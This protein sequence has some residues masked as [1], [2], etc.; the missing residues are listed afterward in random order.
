MKLRKLS[1]VHKRLLSGILSAAMVLSGL[2]ALGGSTA[3]AA[4]ILQNETISTDYTRTSGNFSYDSGE[5]TAY[6]VG[7]ETLG[8]NGW[9]HSNFGETVGSSFNIAAIEQA[10]DR[11]KNGGTAPSGSNHTGT[12]GYNTDPNSAIKTA[13][14]DNW[15]H[16]RYAF[17]A[18]STV[19][20]TITYESSTS[21]KPIGATPPTMANLQNFPLNVNGHIVRNGEVVELSKHDDARKKVEVRRSLKVSDDEQYIIIEYTVHNKSTDSGNNPIPVEFWIGNQTDTMMHRSDNCP[22]ILTDQT[23]NPNLGSDEGITMF[24]SHGDGGQ[25]EAPQYQLTDFKLLTHSGNRDLGVGITKRPS[26][27]NSH[28]RAWVGQWYETPRPETGASDNVRQGAYV[29][30]KGRKTF[31]NV[32]DSSA[33]FSAYMDMAANETKTA[34]FAIRMRTSVYY[35][36]HDYDGAAGT[37]NGFISRPYRSIQ[38]AINAM[39]GYGVKKGYIALQNDETITSTIDIPDGMDITFTSTEFVR[40]SGLSVNGGSEGNPIYN[41]TIPTPVD[42]DAPSK[43]IIR[44]FD[45]PLFN[46]GHEKSKLTIA[47][48]VVDGN[49]VPAV[50]PLIT[51][52]SGE[53]RTKAKSKFVNAILDDTKP[54]VTSTNPTMASAISI[55][56]TAKFE[57]RSGTITD[58]KA[59]GGSAVYIDSTAAKPMDI[60]GEVIIDGNKNK[61]TTTAGENQA[62]VKLGTGK[63]IFVD[64]RGLDGTAK[65]GISVEQSP[66]K[67][68]MGTEAV[69]FEGS[70]V[71]YTGNNFKAD[72]KGT[73]AVGGSTA[74]SVTPHDDPSTHPQTPGRIY[75][76]AGMYSLNIYYVD[77]NGKSMQ[78]NTVHSEFSTQPPASKP[79]QDVNKSDAAAGMVLNYSFPTIFNGWKYSSYTVEPTTATD[80]GVNISST[81]AV[82][83]TMPAKNVNIT[84]K[85]E[86]IGINYVFDPNNG[87]AVINKFETVNPGAVAS[88]LGGLPQ[89][90]RT[91]YQFDGWFPFNDTNPQNGKY[92]AGEEVPGGTQLAAYLVPHASAEGTH[93]YY[94]KWSPGSGTYPIGITYRNTTASL[95]LTFG[96]DTRNLHVDD[97][98]NEM[99][100]NVPGYRYATSSRTPNKGVLDPATGSFTGNMPPLG[101]SLLYRY[102]VDPNALFN[103]NVIHVDSAGNII[104][105]N[106]PTL[107]RRAE[108]PF[109]VSKITLPGYD[110]FRT[111]IAAGADDIPSQF[112]V[113]LNGVLLTGID[114][115]NG[116]VQGYMPNQDV[117]IKFIYN[118]NSAS[119]ITRRFTDREELTK[120]I[121]SDVTNQT[122]NGSV[123]VPAIASMPQLYGYVYDTN[124]SVN[125][126]PPGTQVSANPATGDLFGTMPLSGGVIADYRLS[127]DMSKWQHINFA[128]T[129]NSLGTGTISPTTSARPVLLSDGTAAGDQYAQTFGTI[130]ALGILPTVTPDPYHM[131]EG[132]YFDPA[133]TIP[134]V[135]NMKLA[136]V[137]PPGVRTIYVRLVEDPSK[138]VDIDFVTADPALGSVNPT[139]TYIPGGSPQHLHFDEVWSNVVTPPTTPIANYELK[140][141]TSPA[142]SIMKPTDTVTAGTYKAN[143]GKIGST[144]GLVPGAF[145]ATGHI[146][147]DGSGEIHVHGTQPGN[148]YVVSDP[149][150]IIVGVLPGPPTGTELEFKSLVPGRTYNVREGGPD[151]TA[152]IG[153]PESSIGGSNVSAPK[154]VTIPSIDTNKAVGADPN[155][156]GK[157]QIVIN[158]ADPDA[159]YALI[160]SNGNVVQYPGSDNGWMTPK[161]NNPPTVTFDNLDIGETY[162]VVARKKGNPTETP[163]GNIHA[164]VQVVA[165]PGDMVEA[166]NYTIE[167]RTNGIGANV[168][169][170]TVRGE[171]INAPSYDKIHEN[172][173]FSIHA[174]PTDSNGNHFLYWI[175]MNGRIPGVTG[176]INSNDY[177]GKLSKSNVVFRAVYDLPRLNPAGDKIAPVEEVTRGGSEGEFALDPNG[178]PQLEQD[179]SNPTDVSL[180]NVNRADVRYKIVFNKRTAKTPEVDVVKA[181]P[182]TLWNRYPNAFTAAFALDIKEE[183]YVD[184][185]LVQNASPSN[186]YLKAVVQLDNQDADMLDYEIWDL[187]LNVDAT[188][189][190]TTPTTAA[191]IAIVEPVA[192]NAGLFSFDA[193]VNHTYVLVYAKTFKLYFIDNTPVKNSVYPDNDTSRNF[194]KKIKVRKKDH[195][196]ASEYAADY[197]VVTSYVDGSG[198][199]HLESPFDG[200]DGV[201]YIF[202]DWYK[203]NI[204]TVDTDNEPVQGL[205]FDPNSEVTKTMPIYAYYK[206]NKKAVAKARVD[207]T[208]LVGV[209]N[210]LTLDPYLK[211]GEVERLK[212]AIGIAQNVLD[213]KRGRFD[214]EWD[215]IAERMANYPELQD[216]ID[217]LRRIV[218]EM[219]RLIDQRRN[220]LSSRIG[221]GG[222]GSGSGGR[223]M[224]TKTSAFTSNPQITFT[225]GVDGA[226]EINP[227]TGRWSFV[228]QG[229]LPL[230]NKWAKIQYSNDKG[231]LAT[232]WYRFDKQS[233]L[234][235]GWYRDES[236]GKWYYMSEEAGKK[237]GV[238]QIGWLYKDGKWYYL[239]PVVGEMYVGWHMIG[240]KWYYFSVGNDG[241]PY[242]SLY[243]SETTPDGYKVN[244]DGEWVR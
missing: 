212:I 31:A 50:A 117:T 150:G 11:V 181:V 102:T 58:N 126:T 219:N 223:G 38:N 9:S 119:A 3:H 228:L 241:R 242:G 43:R 110:Y 98:I 186:A 146:G 93:R 130:K 17:G 26:G 87:G 99:P 35:V 90:Q 37:P 78:D 100:V 55:T 129:T 79:K 101:I 225:L 240:D 83:G 125:I 74:N 149:D 192:G 231:K 68:N 190:A 174:D 54:A 224:G 112:R 200:I 202:K 232:D 165:N 210:N 180:I 164:G 141:W 45:G 169:V 153:Q 124:S 205:I 235:T 184:G 196:S 71:P 32:G 171:A 77:H 22:I 116:Q 111:E 155:N 28:L 144:W 163:L 128:F 221:G 237:N 218:D 120:V 33:A 106:T 108:Q 95:P 135:D 63:T 213:R 206:T 152:T 148:V 188:W 214:T 81:G 162:T 34:R 82:T 194:Y 86:K 139:G 226:W 137:P 57:M 158:P 132:W 217:A 64:K 8:S 91:G 233:S 105:T 59:Y 13:Y 151:T 73:S 103:L 238:M 140:N 191:Q 6:V 243:I 198:A 5:N 170:R 29:F 182:S 65:I 211:E 145:S 75:I 179:L 234:I 115:L 67:T 154:P 49:N 16:T 60:A 113:G 216:A 84:I 2:P 207:L 69:T 134:M 4:T 76:Q 80:E 156:E 177:S 104:R 61:D 48:V 244:H 36:D 204:D 178:I 230:N 203:K 109:T 62:N 41:S 183:R 94:A 220:N 187:G 15:W 7:N 167:T 1:K 18:E 159:D 53:V 12:A 21:P 161:G 239:D 56:G 136:I 199:L 66:T 193:N 215:R 40:P 88:T 209:A 30:V 42:Y 10:I 168:E 227:V 27:D 52:S 160:D 172:D 44:G 107:Q 118:S 46:V 121:H 131:V 147:F 157:A 85:L 23:G 208:D 72:K 185:R 89:V 201:T 123:S 142:G 143:F 24:A 189:N 133:G 197:G 114:Q 229:G 236:S 92:D 19:I 97:P 127:K 173:E 122:P 222:G 166:I 70:T 96:T 47:D 39:H 25:S 175:I 51:A 176:R 14:G 138:W 20:P 195:V